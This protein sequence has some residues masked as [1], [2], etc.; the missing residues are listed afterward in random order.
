MA[1]MNSIGEV[2]EF[3]KAPV[4]LNLKQVVNLI[5]KGRLPIGDAFKLVTSGPA[6][7]LSLVNKGIID[8]GNDADLCFFDND[9]N[10][11]DV[12]A[13]GNWMMKDGTIIKKGSFETSLPGDDDDS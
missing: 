10:L 8:T 12:M 11:T 9:F 5:K 3:Y 7:N 6:K 2:I 13:M 4:D 1:R